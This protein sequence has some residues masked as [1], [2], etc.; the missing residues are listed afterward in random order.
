MAAVTVRAK[1]L[2][3]IPFW[4]AVM[5]VAPMAAPVTKPVEPMV[6]VAGLEEVHVAV[7]VR[8]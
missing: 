6:A 7:F 3:A 4:D 2:E 1:L 5:L 8:F